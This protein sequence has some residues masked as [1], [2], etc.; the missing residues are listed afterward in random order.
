[1]APNGRTTKGTD[2]TGLPCPSIIEA[3][4]QM[5]MEAGT[6]IGK[7]KAVGKTHLNLLLTASDSRASH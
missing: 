1:M 4:I 2:Q 5:M 6:T 3:T 7:I